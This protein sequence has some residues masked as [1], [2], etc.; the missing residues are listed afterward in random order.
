MKIDKNGYTIRH[1]E[2]T[3]IIQ[4]MGLG[5]QE[6]FE[7]KLRGIF[8]TSKKEKTRGNLT[9]LYD[10]E[11]N[12]LVFQ[13]LVEVRNHPS[14]SKK[15]V[16]VDAG[17]TSLLSTSNNILSAELKKKKTEDKKQAL[18]KNKGK[19]AETLDQRTGSL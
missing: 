13:R 17:I 8:Y 14:K 3:T 6:P 15:N 10:R 16:G 19:A 5:S 18:L 2:N 11:K 12:R 9:V 1:E 7:V 4:L